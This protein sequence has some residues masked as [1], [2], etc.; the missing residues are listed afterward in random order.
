M[1][2][3]YS[4]WKT[5][6]SRLLKDCGDK[7]R[8]HCNYNPADFSKIRPNFT[9]RALKL[10]LH[11]YLPKSSRVTTLAIKYSGTINIYIY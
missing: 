10:G 11:K 5:I 3:Y 7:F 6:L 8:L 4:P 9:L 2:D 1:P